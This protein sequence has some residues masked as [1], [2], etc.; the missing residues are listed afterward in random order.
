MAACA[1]L[2]SGVEWEAEDAA[3]VV[4]GAMTVVASCPA[5]AVGAAAARV[6]G[7]LLAEL[8]GLLEA[9]QVRCSDN[10][11]TTGMAS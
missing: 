2:S 10:A 7:P 5:E 4:Y 3:A 1:S 11:S 8:G 9:V 6:T